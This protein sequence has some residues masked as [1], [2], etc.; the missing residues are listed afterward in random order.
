MPGPS[1]HM[2]VQGSTVRMSWA[3]QKCPGCTHAS[4]ELQ[5]GVCKD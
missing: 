5:G 2:V 4:H 1:V 3:A